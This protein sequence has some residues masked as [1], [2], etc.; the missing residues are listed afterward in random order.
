MKR[1]RMERR[2]IGT[3]PNTLHNQCHVFRVQLFLIRTEYSV[4]WREMHVPL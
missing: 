1:Q 4:P 2:I 3:I